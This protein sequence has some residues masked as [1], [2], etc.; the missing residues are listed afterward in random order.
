MTKIAEHFDEA[1][2]VLADFASDEQNIQA[3]GHAAAIML[4]ALQSG[5][6][7]IACGNGGS[8]CD[9]MHFAEELTGRYKKDRPPIPALAISDPAH[10][11]CTANDYG[12]A[13]VFSRYVR[14]LGK[15]GDILLAVSTSGNSENIIRAAETASEKGM[16][17]VGLTGSGEGRLAGNCDALVRVPGA[18]GSDRVQ[19]VHI[20]VIH[21]WI[22]FIEQGLF[23]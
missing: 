17:V 14:A 20:K 21:A 2:R 22:D 9:A 10:L 12:Y 8:M 1:A 23:G 13:E 11:T 15:K 18:S 7:I 16:G 6:K 3:V 4:S 5:G 19:E